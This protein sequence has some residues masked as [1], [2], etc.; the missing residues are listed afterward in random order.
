MDL[1][2]KIGQLFFVGFNG[3]EPGPA[4]DAYLDRLSPGGVILFARNIASA[5][6]VRDLNEHIARS[7]EDGTAEW[8]PFIAV[9]QEGGRVSRLRS[10][11]PPLPTAASLAGE[12]DTRIRDYGRALG[13]ALRALGFNTDF[14]PVVD[15]S[16]P[17]AAS[18]IGDRSFGE[19][20][21]VVARC[22]RSFVDGLRE[23]SVASFLKHY[24]G[25]GATEVDSHLSLP[26]CSRSPEELWA[27]DL[28]PYRD[29]AA[30][31][32]G[33]MVGHAH[34][35]GL[36]P[37]STLPATLSTAVVTDLLRGRMAYE[38]LAITDDLEMGAVAGPGP[39]ELA[40]RALLAGN[41]MVMFCN[42]PE[43][44]LAAARGVV[45]AVRGGRLL[46]DRIDRSIRRVLESK[47]RFGILRRTA[48]D[49]S[50]TIAEAIEGLAPFTVS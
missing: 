46:E 23:A 6:Q 30:H 38:G 15:L 9:D 24:P 40:V 49:S 48:E 42:D 50:P 16:S 32:A 45:E 36:D 5:G 39:G 10:I 3:T 31:A 41:D 17:G 19:D 33:I 37:G 44:A 14:A 12:S 29:C 11:L 21:R 4:L 22:A 43:A 27:R 18:G 26:V 20:A 8:A 47:R 1:E 13:V 25:L 34:Y 2:I 35:P 7:C 28:L